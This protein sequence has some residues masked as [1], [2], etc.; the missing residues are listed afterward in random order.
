MQVLQS[1]MI[2]GK[3]CTSLLHVLDYLPAILIN[4][5]RRIGLAPSG[6]EY[7]IRIVFH[8]KGMMHLGLQLFVKNLNRFY[9]YG[10]NKNKFSEI[11]V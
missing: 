10:F 4:N 11:F 7:I 5:G 3:L 8:S 1:K 6:F 9:G 2:V